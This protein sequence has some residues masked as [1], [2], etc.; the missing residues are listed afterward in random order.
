VRIR[1]VEL[2]GFRWFGSSA[3]RIYLQDGLTVVHAATASARACLPKP[4]SSYSRAIQVVV[5]YLVERK[6][7]MT[8]PFAMSTSPARTPGWVCAELELDNGSIVEIRHDLDSDYTP[9]QECR[10]TLSIRSC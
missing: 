3:H 7:N 2:R 5:S 1:W 6:T 4:S 10:S 9:H 8:S